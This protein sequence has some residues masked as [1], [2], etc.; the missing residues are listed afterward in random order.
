M[1]YKHTDYC[2]PGIVSINYA[3]YSYR[4]LAGNFPGGQKVN[5]GKIIQNQERCY[6]SINGEG[7]SIVKSAF[8]RGEDDVPV[9]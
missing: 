1:G 7:L 2:L 3:F 5:I 6:N 4:K 8:T 9:D